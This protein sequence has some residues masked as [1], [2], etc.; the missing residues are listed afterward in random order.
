MDKKLHED[1]NRIRKLSGLTEQEKRDWDTVDPATGKV[2]HHHYS[3]DTEQPGEVWGDNKYKV[4]WNSSDRGDGTLTGARTGFGSG[5]QGSGRGAGTTGNGQGAGQ[6]G[7]GFGSGTSTGQG[8]RGDGTGTGYGGEIQRIP[9]SGTSIQRI[10]PSNGDTGYSD[11]RS[12]S[13]STT[14]YPDYSTS[15]YPDDSDTPV[16]PRQAARDKARQDKQDRLDAQASA[17]A[18]RQ[19]DAQDRAQAAKDKAEQDAYDKSYVNPAWQKEQD[20]IKQQQAQPLP[21]TPT[22]AAPPRPTAKPIAQQLLLPDLPTTPTSAAPPRPTAKPITP[23]PI[24]TLP[25]LPTTPTSAAPPRP[26]AKPITPAKVE[27]APA[28]Q[29]V[30]A[31]SNQDHPNTTISNTPQKVN[32]SSDKIVIPPVLTTKEPSTWDVPPAGEYKPSASTPTSIPKA[33][34]SVAPTLPVAPSKADEPTPVE[35]MPMSAA[36]QEKMFGPM[37]GKSSSSAASPGQTSAGSGSAGQSTSGATGDSGEKGGGANKGKPWTPITPKTIGAPVS[38]QPSWAA[39]QRAT[40]G[41]PFASDK[42]EKD[43]TPA[44]SG[45]TGTTLDTGNDSSIVNNEPRTLTIPGPSNKSEGMNR[46]LQLAGIKESTKVERQFLQ[47]SKVKTN[48]ITDTI[49]RLAG[50][51]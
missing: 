12:S 51:K 14:T 38:D 3:N 6:Q 9:G 17:A 46:M 16:N 28:A 43:S 20:R 5:Q 19:Q 45:G 24:A 18:Q 10:T 2:T 13:Q 1:L 47:E 44:G 42:V 15:T 31:P 35:L 21:T 23:A 50:L 26:T 39:Q 33:S 4:P 40:Q 48:T 49:Q 11:G 30:A 7:T 36:D 27:P 8:G 22:S 41:I 25:D 34:I 29:P 37:P 32:P